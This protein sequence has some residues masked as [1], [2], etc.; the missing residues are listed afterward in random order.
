MSGWFRATALAPGL[1]RLD[2]PSVHADF[3]ANVFHLR[4]RD[5]DLL[6]DTGIGL[7]PL[8]PEIGT[9]G[10]PLI[11]VA[12][13]IHVDHVGGLH[14]FADRRGPAASAVAFARMDDA[15]TLAHLFRTLKR[16]VARP[17]APG[18]SARGYRIAPAPLTQSLAEGDSVDLG[19][20]RLTVLALPGHSPD[21]IGLL[22]ERDGTLF[23]GDAVYDE[24]LYDHL[25]G[26]DPAVYRETLA[27]LKRLAPRVVHGG[28]GGSFGR[29]RL[30]AI[31]EAYLA[32]P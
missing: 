27:R 9:G 14:E 26:S 30:G 31:V 6:V 24:E 19:D 2:E 11:A 10:R 16:P 7:S 12:T 17:P 32:R 20:R 29:E 21:S 5:A 23:S 15:D 22:D 25:P 13:H 18:W 4:G 8:A 1:T 3:R 28:H